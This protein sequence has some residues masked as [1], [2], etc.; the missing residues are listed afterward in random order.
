[1]VE[2]SQICKVCS[3]PNCMVVSMGYGFHC[4]N[5]RGNPPATCL[6]WKEKRR[7]RC[8]LCEEA[9]YYSEEGSDAEPRIQF[10][11]RTPTQT[12]RFEPATPVP[13]RRK[14]SV[15]AVATVVSDNINS[16]WDDL[17]QAKE[18]LLNEI[19]TQ[20]DYDDLKAHFLKKLKEM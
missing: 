20:E 17:K 14:S 12:Q 15:S 4:K 6:G 13:K 18:A 11:Q 2:V 8:N 9:G 16:Y 10:S 3:D 7:D 5:K 19:I 1:M